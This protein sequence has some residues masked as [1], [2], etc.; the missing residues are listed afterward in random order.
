MTLP[1]ADLRWPELPW[2]ISR[3][4]GSELSDEEI[5]QM[6]YTER[7]NLLNSNPVLLALHFQYR[8]ELFFKE[9]VINGPLGKITFHVIRVEFQVRGG[10]HIHSFLWVV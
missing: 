7:C 1:F 3:L 6:E 5:H 10:P 9:I 4:N 8:V 2:I